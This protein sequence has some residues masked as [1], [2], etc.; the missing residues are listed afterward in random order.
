[1]N[2]PS[3]YEFSFDCDCWPISF[4]EVLGERKLCIAF[5]YEPEDNGDMIR[6][7]IWMAVFARHDGN[8]EWEDITHLVEAKEHADFVQQCYD[9][10]KETQ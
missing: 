4:D 8:E 9:Y 10:L 6:E 5:D 3:D 1:M 7:G 2:K